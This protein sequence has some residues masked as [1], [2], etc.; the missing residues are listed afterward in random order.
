MEGAAGRKNTEL[1]KGNVIHVMSLQ[2]L[3][4]SPDDVVFV[5]N[6]RNLP[7]FL[8]VC[9]SEIFNDCQQEQL[10]IHSRRCVRDGPVQT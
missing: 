3:S 7:P 6:S 4:R 8:D 1:C 2:V 5:A 9:C 10:P